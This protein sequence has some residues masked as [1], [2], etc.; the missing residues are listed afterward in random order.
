MKEVEKEGHLLSPRKEAKKA[1]FS[2]SR[3]LSRPC[4][5]LASSLSFSGAQFGRPGVKGGREAVYLCGVGVGV[6]VERHEC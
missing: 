3:R 2:L 5:S 1:G 4:R 6:G